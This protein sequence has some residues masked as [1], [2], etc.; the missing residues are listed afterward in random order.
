MLPN[1]RDDVVKAAWNVGINDI[2]MP[3]NISDIIPLARPINIDHPIG[4]VNNMNN[5]YTKFVI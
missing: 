2:S 3:I 5:K 1:A 4:A